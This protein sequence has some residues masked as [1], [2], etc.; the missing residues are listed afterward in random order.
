MTL[1]PKPILLN[2]GIRLDEAM[3]IR[4]A[5]VREHEDTGLQAIHADSTH[6]ER[7]SSTQAIEAPPTCLWSAMTRTPM[8]E[9]EGA[10]HGKFGARMLPDILSPQS[11]AP[12]IIYTRRAW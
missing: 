6:A 7:Y 4:H 10:P 8:P 12:A 3:V 5:Y 11:S 2:A 1:T 9:I